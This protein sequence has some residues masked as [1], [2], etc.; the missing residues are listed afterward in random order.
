[1]HIP[2]KKGPTFQQPE[3][4]F[5]AKGGGK[6]VWAQGFPNPKDPGKPAQ[7]WEKDRKP[8]PGAQYSVPGKKV[9]MVSHTLVPKLGPGVRVGRPSPRRGIHSPKG[10]CLGIRIPRNHT[11]LCRGG[12]DPSSLR[13]PSSETG[14]TRARANTS[15]QNHRGRFLTLSSPQEVSHFISA[16]T[17]RWGNGS[18]SPRTA[19]GGGGARLPG[20]GGPRW[21][22]QRPPGRAPG[23][24]AGRGSPHLFPTRRGAARAR[25]GRG[26]AAARGHGAAAG[27]GWEQSVPAWARLLPARLRRAVCK[28]KVSQ[29][30]GERVREL[31]SWSSR[32]PS[33]HPRPQARPATYLSGPAAPCG[34]RPVS[35]RGAWSSLGSQPGPAAARWG[36]PSAP[37]GAAQLRGVLPPRRAAPAAARPSPAGASHFVGS[38]AGSGCAPPSRS[39]RDAGSLAPAPGSGTP[40]S[41]PPAQPWFRPGLL[42]AAPPPPA[43]RPP[44]RMG[45]PFRP[46]VALS[47]PQGRPAPDSEGLRLSPGC[48]WLRAGGA[49]T[50]TRRGSQ[51]AAREDHVDQT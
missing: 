4:K 30:A 45:V 22:F 9:P 1:M 10:R 27:P 32:R 2:G 8:H 42:P 14:S 19:P 20:K 44:R 25:P 51:S 3:R 6:G 34:L 11:V 16:L 43:P 36:C 31:G 26:V 17:E 29:G 41:P 7:A 18:D 48:E 46:P 13:A 47:G 28:H 15:A 33:P 49:A 38:S 21:P 39:S 12:R 37:P 23:P 35:P 40:A 50:F 5:L 24:P